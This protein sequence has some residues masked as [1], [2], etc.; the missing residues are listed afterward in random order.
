MAG[1]GLP[2]SMGTVRG[3]TDSFPSGYT[4][5]FQPDMLCSGLP[6][7]GAA[8]HHQSPV[9]P[10]KRFIPVSEQR[11]ITMGQDLSPP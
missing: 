3:N 2:A 9:S 6:E 8:H 7:R 4:L 5:F 10:E 11:R 1:A